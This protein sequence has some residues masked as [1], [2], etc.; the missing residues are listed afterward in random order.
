MGKR[1]LFKVKHPS[2][3]S[4]VIFDSWSTLSECAVDFAS[5]E[6]QRQMRP[7]FVRLVE[8]MADDIM[9]SVEET[10]EP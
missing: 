7:E 5:E 10:D 1:I 8:E 9:K 2:Y 3:L 4:D 6:V